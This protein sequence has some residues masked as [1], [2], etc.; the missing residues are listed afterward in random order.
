MNYVEFETQGLTYCTL[1]IVWFVIRSSNNTL[2][3][4]A[5][6]GTKQCKKAWLYCNMDYLLHL[7]DSSDTQLNL[8]LLELSSCLAVIVSLPWEKVELDAKCI[9]DA[10]SS[11]TH[12]NVNQSALLDDCRQLSTRFR[13]IRFNHCYREAN[14][15]ANGLARKGMLRCYTLPCPILYYYL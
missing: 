9:I 13:H 1:T 11:P 15:C 5:S 2:D 3:I 4:P 14:Q 6:K 10:L 8:M 12:S 7:L